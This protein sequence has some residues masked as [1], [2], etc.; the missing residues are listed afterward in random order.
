VIEALA[1]QGA[2]PKKLCRMLGVA[3]SGFFYWRSKPPSIRELRHEQLSGLI[4]DIHRTSMG[5]YGSRRVAAELRLGYEILANRKAVAALMRRLGLQGLP[6]R[7]AQRRG[8]ASDA[9]AAN[10]LVLRQFSRDA[11]N[12]LWLTDITEEDVRIVVEF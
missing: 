11:P 1:G 5:T 2:S 10:D 9:A 3:P 8:P 12:R 7:K 4:I 6:K